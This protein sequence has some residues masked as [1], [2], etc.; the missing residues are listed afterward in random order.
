MTIPD[1]EIPPTKESVQQIKIDVQARIVRVLASLL[2]IMVFFGAG[3]LYVAL[4]NRETAHNAERTSIIAKVISE[5]AVADR[6]QMCQFARLNRNAIRDLA[7]SVY[8]PIQ[9]FPDATQAEIDR[10][11]IRNAIAAR[12]LDDFVKRNQPISC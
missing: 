1:S 7:A 3:L 4:N 8:A 11:A 5:E 2:L 12:A 9:P 10:V 6:A